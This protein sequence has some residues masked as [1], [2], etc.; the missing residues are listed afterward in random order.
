MQE[1]ILKRIRKIDENF[2]IKDSNND[3]YWIIENEKLL[4]HSTLRKDDEEG[5][6]NIDLYLNELISFKYQRNEYLYN[7]DQFEIIIGVLFDENEIDKFLKTSRDFGNP[8]DKKN[9]YFKISNYSKYFID[10]TFFRESYQWEFYQT[11]KIFNINSVTGIGVD[12]QDFLK[13]ANKIC[14]SIVFELEQKQKLIPRFFNPKLD[15]KQGKAFYGQTYD[16]TPDL[17]D[18]KKI[19]FSRYDGDLVNYYYRALWM[20]ESEFKYLAFFQVIE[21]LFDEVFKKELVQDIRVI[22]ESSWFSTQNDSDIEKMIS[23]IERYNKDKNDKIKTKLV[24]DRY[25]KTEVHDEAFFLANKDI[26]AILIDLKLI[27]SESELKD[28][29]KLATYIYDYRC[30]CTHSNR[31]YPIKTLV[32]STNENLNKYIALIKKI[33]ERI[34][35]NYK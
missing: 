3:K 35:I 31:D 7:T 17:I 21:C 26:V 20:E 18:F 28:L 33:A 15:E 16:F 27:S 30:D 4:T 10:K 29:Q 24:L 32:K 19:D 9:I 13:V 14:K 2:S 22:M 6:K 23:I 34:I 5:I 1:Q 25:F 12:D 8:P 11:I